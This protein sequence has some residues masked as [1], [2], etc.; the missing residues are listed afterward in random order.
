MK[1]HQSEEIDIHHLWRNKVC[2]GI[3]T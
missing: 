3:A 1:F 2:P